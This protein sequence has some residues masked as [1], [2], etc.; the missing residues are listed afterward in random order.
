MSL[1]ERLR[2]DAGSHDIAS[3]FTFDERVVTSIASD[4][5]SG[6]SQERYKAWRD[7]QAGAR[8]PEYLVPRVVRHVECAWPR[9]M[10]RA[11]L[12]LSNEQL[13]ER[14]AGLG[15]WYVPFVLGDGVNTMEFTDDFGSAIFAD[16]NAMRM[17]F[18]S[19]LIGGTIERLFGAEL[20]EC[21]V[22]DIGCN[23]GWF[24]FD[25]AERGARSVDG[26]DLRAHNIEQARFLAGYFGF[27]QTNFAVADAT[28]FDDDRT[29]DVVLNLGVLYHVTDPLAFVRRTYELCTR[30]AVLDT[31]CHEE[32]FSG[33]VLFNAKDPSHPHEGRESWEFHPTYRGAIDALRYAGFREIVEVV[34]DADTAAGLYRGGARRCFLAIK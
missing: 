19:D 9:F 7:T 32:P 6:T 11:A 14:L 2:A 34:A 23:S 3:G 1:V 31:I 27:P 17:Q 13:R 22:L 26:V 25:L 24:S 30:F 8:A 18:R 15:P 4:S 20:G 12:A 33:F 16:D 5:E 10:E 21:S 28:A 29:W